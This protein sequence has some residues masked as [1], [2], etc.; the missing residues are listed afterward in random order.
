METAD[1][2]GSPFMAPVAWPCRWALAAAPWAA[3]AFFSSTVD[4]EFNREWRGFRDR[5]GLVWSQRLR[6]QFNRAAA[7]AG[8]PVHLGW[9]GLRITGSVAPDPARPLATMR[10]ALARFG[11]DPIKDRKGL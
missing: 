2:A 11:P 7:H 6:E 1:L 9:T 10:A 4:S 3:L 5:F 8:W